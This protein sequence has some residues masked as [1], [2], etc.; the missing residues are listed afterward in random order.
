MVILCDVVVRSLSK[1][2]P[3]GGTGGERTTIFIKET[4]FDYSIIV[5]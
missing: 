5:E 3:S 2:E 1:K 4:N